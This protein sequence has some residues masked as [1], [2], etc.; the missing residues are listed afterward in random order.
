M[1]G[2]S[3]MKIVAY[4]LVTGCEYDTL[5]IVGNGKPAM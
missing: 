2:A 1:S 5:I 3:A 4:D